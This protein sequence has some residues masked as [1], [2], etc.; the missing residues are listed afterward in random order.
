MQVMDD[1]YKRKVM[2]DIAK[3]WMLPVEKVLEAIFKI[4]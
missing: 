3:E 1:E 2:F 4:G